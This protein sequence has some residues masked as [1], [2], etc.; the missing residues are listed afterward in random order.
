MQ[1]LTRLAFSSAAVLL[2][3]AS[4]V[5]AGDLNNANVLQLSP[6]G[7]IDGNT[8]RIDQRLGTGTTIQG[9]DGKLLSIFPLTAG[10]KFAAHVVAN[11]ITDLSLQ[12]TNDS[13]SAKQIGEANDAEI[14]VSGTGG[15]IELFQSAGPFTPFAAGAASGA[16]TATITADGNALGGIIQVGE[17]NQATL[18]LTDAKGLIT[19]L[20][21]NLSSDLSVGAGGSGTVVQV[22][23]NSTTGTVNVIGGTNLTYV[24]VGNNLSQS[25]A[26][27]AYSTSPANIIITQ[28]RWW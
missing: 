27:S 28:T 19:Q 16:N 25:S 9:I 26:V 20:G 18:S 22:G 15:T 7:S 24:Q 6:A 11:A 17:L 21:N 3:A 23:S 10:G 2:L 5:L 13:A 14:T 12:T 4:P 8:L 1:F